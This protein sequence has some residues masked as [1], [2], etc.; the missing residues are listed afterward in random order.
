MPTHQNLLVTINALESLESGNASA[1]Q[2]SYYRNRRGVRS[3]YVG[4]WNGRRYHTISVHNCQRTLPASELAYLIGGIELIDERRYGIY[5]D[6]KNIPGFYATA[7]STRT[8]DASLNHWYMI[9]HSCALDFAEILGQKKSLSVEEE[10]LL[11]YLES[12][13]GR[14]RICA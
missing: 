2:P 5:A 7:R 11:K 10:D 13:N 1:W 12:V 14:S 9:G 3:M 8:F 6:T 4:F